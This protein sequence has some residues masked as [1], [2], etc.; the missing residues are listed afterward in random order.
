MI[1]EGLLQWGS[2]Q[3]R[4]GGFWFYGGVQLR[5]GVGAGPAVCGVSAHLGLQGSGGV[6]LHKE[7]VYMGCVSVHRVC[8]HR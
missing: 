6:S 1:V 7:N 4:R 5:G 2:I 3:P 8:V